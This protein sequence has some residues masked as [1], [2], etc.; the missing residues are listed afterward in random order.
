[1]WM[2]VQQ[3]EP[4]VWIYCQNE[5]MTNSTELDPFL[6]YGGEIVHL[7]NVGRES[8]SFL[9]HITRHYHE[10]AN[11]TLFSQDIPEAMLVERFEVRKPHCRFTSVK[12]KGRLAATSLEFWLKDRPESLPPTSRPMTF[13]DWDHVSDPELFLSDMLTMS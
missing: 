4:Y 3:W 13:Q 11:Y 7:E 1:M 9:Q 6:K 5:N 2:Q 12:H 10:L 8:H